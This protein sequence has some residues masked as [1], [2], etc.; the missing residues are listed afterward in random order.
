MKKAKIFLLS[1]LF[2]L[3][4]HAAVITVVNPG[5]NNNLN[6]NL[7]AAV[8][9][10]VIGDTVQIPT[11]VFK[12]TTANITINKAISLCGSA[13]GTVL[14]R[15]EAY[16]D[17][18]LN[19]ETMITFN[20]NSR[21]PCGVEVYNLELR[22]QIPLINAGDGGS[23]TLDVG[24]KLVNATGF[25]VYNCTFKWFGD[26]GLQIRH[27]DD[28]CHGLIYNN[29]FDTNT[30]GLDGLGYGYGVVIYGQSLKWVDEPGYGTDNFVFIENNTFYNHRHSISSAGC[31]RFVFRYNFIQ[32]N[33]LNSPYWQAIDAGHQ[34]REDSPGTNRHGTAVA[35]IYGNK[36]T[37][38][39]RIDGVTAMANGCPSS[40][41]EERG[42]GIMNGHV[43][44]Y[45]DTFAGVRFPIGFIQNESTTYPYPFPEQVGAK[46]GKR[47]G[48][49]GAGTDLYS[50]EGNAWVW[51]ISH[52]VYTLA[53]GAITQKM[54]NYTAAV[55]GG[56]GV[57]TDYI[58]PGRDYN[59]NSG[60]AG[61][62]AKPLYTPYPHPHPYR[63]MKYKN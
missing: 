22:S 7:N 13:P 60:T 8:S 30:K 5:N 58:A 54:F 43:L 40:Q 27:Y 35:E 63:N 42:I 34:A 29:V 14:Y 47:E 25:K 53:S 62:G 59:Y 6:T 9:A 10:A 61:A 20:I 45:N 46:S 48:R 28:V 19:Y 32:N 1:F 50:T 57:S 26:S 56:P 16:T 3:V 4:A 31:A 41:M 38:T 2:S 51:D 24:L 23:L 55:Y 18:D 15:D 11:G 33:R 44:C 37:N 17:G 12:I 36:V 39:T 49:S 52:I 21:I